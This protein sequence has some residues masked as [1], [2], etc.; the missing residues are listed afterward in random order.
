MESFK[1]NFL[2]LTFLL[3]LSVPLYGWIAHVVN[4][5]GL[6]KMLHSGLVSLASGFLTAANAA[7]F[8]KFLYKFIYI[9]VNLVFML[10]MLNR[11]NELGG[12]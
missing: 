4:G 1:N 12:I 11:L 3:V 8:W 10:S 9:P 7:T 5:L 2:V 6:I